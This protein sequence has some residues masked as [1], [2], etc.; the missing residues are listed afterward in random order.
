[1]ISSYM[2]YVCA[3]YELVVVNAKR[4]VH[5]LL[6]FPGPHSSAY[7]SQSRNHLRKTY[8]AKTKRCYV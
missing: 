3:L 6:G 5:C 1:M 4:S 7:L 8:S 2:F